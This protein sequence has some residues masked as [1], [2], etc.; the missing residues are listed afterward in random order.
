M[1]TKI[2]AILGMVLIGLVFIGYCGMNFIRYDGHR[3]ISLY[4]AQFRFGKSFFDSKSFKDGDESMRASMAVD[5]IQKKYYIGRPIKLV[6]TE[7]GD[8]TSYFVSDEIPAYVISKEPKSKTR[9]Q[10]YFQIVFLSDGFGNVAEVVILS[11]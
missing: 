3:K 9:Q 2:L 11:K 4:E 7:L 6:K 1:R 10:N 8:Q 5:L